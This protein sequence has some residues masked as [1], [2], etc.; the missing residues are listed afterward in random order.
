MSVEIWGGAWKNSPQRQYPA[1]FHHDG[2][3]ALQEIEVGAMNWTSE[4]EIGIILRGRA[5]QDSNLRQLYFRLPKDTDN[6]LART[7]LSYTESRVPQIRLR[8]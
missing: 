2:D 3:M 1:G 5:G 6:A 4:N 8:L 7:T